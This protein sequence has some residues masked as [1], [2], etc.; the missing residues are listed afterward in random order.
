MTLTGTVNRYARLRVGAHVATV[1]R[2]DADTA[3]VF[4]VESPGPV[5]TP[6]AS[7]QR[8]MDLAASA[9]THAVTHAAQTALGARGNVRVWDA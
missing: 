1:T 7:W 8:A 6:C 3:P 4:V 9:V 2:V 5:F